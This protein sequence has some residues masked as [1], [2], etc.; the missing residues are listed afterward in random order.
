MAVQGAN[1]LAELVRNLSLQFQNQHIPTCNQ[2]H[3]QATQQIQHVLDE[4]GQ[5]I[6]A[7]IR[8]LEHEWQTHLNALKTAEAWFEHHY[9]KLTTIAEDIAKLATDLLV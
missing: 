6:T 3:T 7:E 9:P 5:W 4:G 1:E 2:V 8:N